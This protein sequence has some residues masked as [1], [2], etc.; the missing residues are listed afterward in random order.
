MLSEEWQ[1]RIPT[2][3]KYWGG[4]AAVVNSQK[5]RG[6]NDVSAYEAVYGQ[7]LDHPLCC[8]QDEARRCWSV[9]DRMMVTIE[10]EFD[11]YVSDH[12]GKRQLPVIGLTVPVWL[13][14]LVLSG[15][16]TGTAHPSFFDLHFLSLPTCLRYIPSS[17]HLRYSTTTNMSRCRPTLQRLWPS[18]SMGR[19]LAPPTHGAVAPYG[20]MKGARHR[21]RR[22]RCWFPCL[23][24][25]NATHQK[26]ER[27]VGPWPWV[28]VDRSI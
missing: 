6:K 25:R 15:A 27:E 2:G 9:K 4:V 17:F 12:S 23:G 8:T 24:H 16:R 13:L 14:L 21:V 22:R 28:A 10:P 5:G 19:S 3:Q 20:P 11:V 26:T 1:V 7:V 18:P